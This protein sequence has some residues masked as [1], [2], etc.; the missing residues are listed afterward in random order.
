MT[1]RSVNLITSL[2]DDS[3]G[4]LS[5][6]RDSRMMGAMESQTALKAVPYGRAATTAYD[7]V[8]S[9]GS[10][11]VFNRADLMS[12]PSS[13]AAFASSSYCPNSHF[14]A[15]GISSRV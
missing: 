10:L 11:Y 13:A 12:P 1:L 4:A 7:F 9:Y 5:M 8:G 15:G 3:A 6:L 2:C 14:M